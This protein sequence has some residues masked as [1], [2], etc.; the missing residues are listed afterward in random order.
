[1]SQLAALAAVAVREIAWGIPRVNRELALWRQRAERI[2]DPGLRADA[3]ATL[4]FEHMNPRGAALFAVLPPGRN[5]DLLQVLVAFQVA[6][7]YLDTLTERPAADELPHGHQLHRALVDALDPGAPVADY[8]H[9]RPWED[10]GGYLRDLVE[11]CR[12]GCERLP[13]YA[14]VRPWLL[15]AAAGLSVQVLNHLADPVARDAALDAWA[16][17]NGPRRAGLTWF[18]ATGAASSNLGIYALLAAAAD[19]RLEQSDAQRIH[20]AYHPN[21]CLLCTLMDSFS[22]VVEDEST[23]AHSYVAHYPH[24]ADAVDRI[25]EL[26]ASSIAAVRRLPAGETHAVIVAGMVAM[27]LASRPADDPRHSDARRIRRHA[28]WLAAA[29]LPVTR[30]M[31][32]SSQS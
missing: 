9:H 14:V 17:A 21:V 18:E 19:P 3:L 24:A 30:I 27:Y 7:D 16:T 1:M 2:P 6:M 32:A 10:D 12:R 22:D 28:G 25:C 13:S 15:E 31:Q 20:A 5:E 26:V 4:R 8:H 11:A 23:G 29:A